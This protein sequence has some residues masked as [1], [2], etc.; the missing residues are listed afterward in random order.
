MWGYDS[1]SGGRM[2]SSEFD[3]EFDIDRSMRLRY[4]IEKAFEENAELL[5]RLG[6]D[7]DENGVPYWETE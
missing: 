6:S 5:D 2:N 1:D 4:A 7:Y 3:N